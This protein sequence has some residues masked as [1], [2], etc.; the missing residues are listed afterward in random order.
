MFEAISVNHHILN[1]YIS[2]LP[3]GVRTDDRHFDMYRSV[4]QILSLIKHGQPLKQR[5][6][7]SQRL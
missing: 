7:D 2:V 3:S 6:Q 1:L 4:G 5:Y